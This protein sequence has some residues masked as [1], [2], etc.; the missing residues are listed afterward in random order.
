M[1]RSGIIS[2]TLLK[3]RRATRK[4]Q[5]WPARV[6]RRPWKSL[7]AGFIPAIIFRCAVTYDR[8]KLAATPFPKE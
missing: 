1:F 4:K 7:M 8:P 2:L 3:V 6:N 5:K